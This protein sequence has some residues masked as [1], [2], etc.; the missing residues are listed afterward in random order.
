MPKLISSKDAA[1]ATDPQLERSLR[2][3]LLTGVALVLL[4]PAARGQSDWLGWLP[5]WLV[6]MPA[7]ALWSLHR[8]RLPL[9]KVASRGDASPSLRR[10]RPGTQA[11]RRS[12]PALKRLPRAA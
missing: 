11:R 4:L 5:M 12:M 8:F 2:L 6:G 3:L 10:R 9:R 7:V 1:I